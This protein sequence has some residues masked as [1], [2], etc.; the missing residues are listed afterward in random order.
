MFTGM[1][2]LVVDDAVNRRDEIKKAVREM[3]KGCR[4]DDTGSVSHGMRLA[5]AHPY[6]AAIIDL[7]FE[8][9]PRANSD[10]IEIPRHLTGDTKMDDRWLDGELRATGGF[11]V[12]FAI[13]QAVLHRK[14]VLP[15]LVV[16]L[17]A[18]KANHA[19]LKP[20]SLRM[21]APGKTL[22]G[23]SLLNALA[24]R[25]FLLGEYDNSDTL[26]V[27]QNVFRDAELIRFANVAPSLALGRAIAALVYVEKELNSQDWE[28]LLPGLKAC[29]VGHGLRLWQVMPMRVGEVAKSR[30]GRASL[31]EARSTLATG[32]AQSNA[33]HRIFRK[34]KDLTEPATNYG[35]YL[36]H[37]LP[38][39]EA[40]TEFDIWQHFWNEF[41]QLPG[42]LQ[43]SWLYGD[44]AFPGFC[45]TSQLVDLHLPIWKAEGFESRAKWITESAA[46]LATRLS[47]WR[48]WSPVN[49]DSACAH[50][51]KMI[52]AALATVPALKV[53]FEFTINAM[54]C[55][56]WTNY[57]LI[58]HAIANY[59][60]EEFRHLKDWDCNISFGSRGTSIYV[61]IWNNLPGCAQVIQ[62]KPENPWS[63]LHSRMVP[64]VRDV[65]V[66]D[67]GV[68]R[69]WHGGDFDTPCDGPADAP[70]A[71][72]GTWV[73]VQIRH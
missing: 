65:I 34:R 32:L 21:P 50:M 1:R 42:D 11:F 17:S 36:F 28:E 2:V 19:K 13:A 35:H 29:G 46:S 26:S 71:T 41:S 48:N 67:L 7:Y 60:L 57:P 33:L 5:Q 8:G 62:G 39:A 61:D 54:A 4:I 10:A 43:T 47:A 15:P 49:A 25:P 68:R 55:E 20:F 6:D 52:A 70:A 3:W 31:D 16:M 51:Q 22:Q 59:L 53:R 69:S 37:Q 56:Y 72:C 73:R 40:D 38:H 14:A 63:R 12:A 18:D 9:P 27:L 66:T 45:T 64:W 44:G 23:A 58:A 24:G 30:G